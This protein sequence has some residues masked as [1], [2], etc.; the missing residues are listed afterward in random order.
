[1]Q[2]AF[3]CCVSEHNWHHYLYVLYGYARVYRIE[4]DY[5]Q[6]RFYLDL[7]EK[8]VIQ[9]EF[10]NL[11]REIAEER[12]KLNL[13]RVDLEIDVNRSLIRTREGEINLRRQHLLIEIIHQLALSHENRVEEDGKQ[14][15]S[16]QEII[17]TVWKENYNP[18]A[19]D[20]KLYYNINRIRKLLE[21][22][23]KKPT[24][25]LNWRQGYRLAPELKVRVVQ[26]GEVV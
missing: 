22:D 21:P 6:A 20:G 1:L 2:K 19:H 8:A 3:T 23:Q 5:V 14:G 12:V 16:K 9:D 18:E 17:E 25:L 26:G 4:Q 7:L 10:K 13:N 11:R 15:L 24:Y